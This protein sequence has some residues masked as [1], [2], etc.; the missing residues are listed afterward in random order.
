MA[1]AKSEILSYFRLSKK[2]IMSW[3]WW[4]TLL[5]PVIGRQRQV[6]LFEFETSMVYRM[7]SRTARVAQRNPVSQNQNKQILQ[8]IINNKS[9]PWEHMVSMTLGNRFMT[10]ILTD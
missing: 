8:K 7:S 6:D 2:T 4:H 10:Q 5:N 3:V 1:E 9:L